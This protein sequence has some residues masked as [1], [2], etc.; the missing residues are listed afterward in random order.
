MLHKLSLIH[1][2]NNTKFILLMIDSDFNSK[3]IGTVTIQVKSL[4][5]ELLIK[6]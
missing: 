6:L 4:I 1:M 2:D 5:N 3:Y